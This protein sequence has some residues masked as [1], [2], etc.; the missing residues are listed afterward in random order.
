MRRHQGSSSARRVR[1]ATTTPEQRDYLFALWDAR[2]GSRRQRDTRACHDWGSVLRL[3]CGP[4]SIALTASQGDRVHGAIVTPMTWSEFPSDIREVFQGFRSLGQASESVLEQNSSSS[5]VLP[6]QIQRQLSGEE[7]GHYRQPFANPGEDRRPT[8]SWPRNI[9]IDGEPSRCRRGG[10]GLRRFGA[11]SDVPKMF[12]NAQ[13]APR[14]AAP[15]SS[16]GRLNLTE[17]TVSGIHFE[18]TSRGSH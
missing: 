13:R 15:S 10:R 6:A 7:M 2:L 16:S 11:E 14:S 9:P 3:R 4:T 1:T 17:T 18:R 12:I 5:R 8:L